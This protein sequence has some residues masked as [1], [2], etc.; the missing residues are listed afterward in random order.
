MMKPGDLIFD[1]NKGVQGMIVEVILPDSMSDWVA[2][3]I[4]L[5]NDGVIDGAYFN[6]V[7]YLENCF[8]FCLEDK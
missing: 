5:Y 8:P 4:I 2:D 6:D 3:Y 7:D 1:R